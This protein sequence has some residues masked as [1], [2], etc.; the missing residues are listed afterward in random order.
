MKC[1]MCQ[2]MKPPWAILKNDGIRTN[3]EGNNI[4]K[5]I[6]ICSYLCNQQL[7]ESLPP[8]KWGE[9]LINRDDFCWLM[10]TIKKENKIFEFLTIQEIQG[11]TD[12]QKENYY[13]EREI[14]LSLD[15]EKRDI[16]NELDEQDYQT[17]MIEDEEFSSESEYDDY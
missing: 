14:Y 7:K 15:S 6:H 12:D 2:S 4:G 1:I 10:P 17:M 16:Y 5:E 3:E 9:I 13:N 11:M 8:N